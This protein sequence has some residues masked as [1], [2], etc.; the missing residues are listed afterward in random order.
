MLVWGVALKGRG[1]GGGVR[2]RT[3]EGGIEAE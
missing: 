1:S 2:T 3:R